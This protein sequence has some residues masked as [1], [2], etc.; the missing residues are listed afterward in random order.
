MQLR[1]GW[2]ATSSTSAGPRTPLYLRNTRRM[3]LLYGRDDVCGD[4]CK[5]TRDVAE[6]RSTG[7]PVD[8]QGG[9]LKLVPRP[10]A[11]EPWTSGAGGARCLRHPR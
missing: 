10:P 5:H 4:L 9:V 6:T 11:L 8:E 1:A 2:D 3:L 7:H